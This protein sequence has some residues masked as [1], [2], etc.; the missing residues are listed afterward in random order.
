MTSA[1]ALDV[2]TCP[3]EGIEPEKY[4]EL[5]SLT[6]TSYQTLCACAAGYR[7][8]SDALAT[9]KKVRF[10]TKEVMSYFL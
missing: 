4:D 9:M 6:N 7:H 2:D 1:A 5:L 10:E 8:P 3:M